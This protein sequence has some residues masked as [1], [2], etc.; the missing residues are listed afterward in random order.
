MNAKKIGMK[1]FVLILALVLLIG[2]VAGGTIAYLMTATPAVTNTFVAGNIGTLELTE[3][4][5][6]NN[7]AI[8]VPGHDIAKD[9]TVTFSG[10]NV[11]AYVFLKVERTGWSYTTLSGTEGNESYVYYMGDAYEEGYDKRVEAV[12]ADGWLPVEGVTDVYYREVDAENTASFPVIKGNV[13][14]VSE[15]IGMNNIL[16]FL[17][18]Y[19]E[20]YDPDH[21]IE[22]F[23]TTLGFKAYA[24]QMEK[25]ANINFT[26]AE[27]WTQLVPPAAEPDTTD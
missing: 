20:V 1:A 21:T 15:T 26:P 3:T 2:C 12:I 17:D 11:D 7:S 19:N 6:A 18:D 27:A 23:T 4:V 10:N 8:V 5:P 16:D 25:A 24:I 22:T 13:I 14:D 9:P